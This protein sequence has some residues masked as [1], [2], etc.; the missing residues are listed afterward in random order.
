VLGNQ[1]PVTASAAA[2]SAAQAMNP[3]LAAGTAVMLSNS[4]KTPAS[5]GFVSDGETDDPF[6][7]VESDS[8]ADPFGEVDEFSDSEGDV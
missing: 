5:G 7:D 4:F 6:G 1:T 2:S 3:F 8:D